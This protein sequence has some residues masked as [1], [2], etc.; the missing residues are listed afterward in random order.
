MCNNPACLDKYY[1]VII[2]DL[3]MPVMDGFDATIEIKKYQ[4]SLNTNRECKIV[5]LTAYENEETISRCKQVGMEKVYNKPASQEDIKEIFCLNFYDLI[6][7][8]FRTFSKIE[9]Q[10]QIQAHLVI[11]GQAISSS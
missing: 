1:R 5:A 9:K 11:K 2:M 10:L 7:E 3:Q 6:S 8:N 4:N